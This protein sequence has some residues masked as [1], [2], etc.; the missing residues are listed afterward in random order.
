MKK[1]P[2]FFH[3]HKNAGTYIYHSSWRTFF[4]NPLASSRP[5]NLEILKENKVSYRMICDLKDETQDEKYIRLNRSGVD[6]RVD[7]DD[8]DFNDL[9]IYFIEICG[10]SF[11]SYKEEI[12]KNLPTDLE[13]YEF[14][15]LREPYSRIQSLYSYIHT[16]KP[17]NEGICDKSFVEY[18]NSSELECGW[19]IRVLSDIPN[20][21]PICQE[22]YD[23]TCRILDGM[24]VS[25][26]D[27]VDQELNKIFH[28]CYRI[29]A[30][31]SPP[32]FSNK[33]QEKINI[34]FNQLDDN[35]K[36]TFLNNTKWDIK[37]YNRYFTTD[38]D[39]YK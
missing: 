29:K 1:L 5:W 34:S 2:V 19:L 27:N 16:M 33:T 17:I 3:I 12:Y 11:N 14:I 8:L 25:N 32:D 7:I 31:K 13:L 38:I 21:I 22:H 39:K 36:T 35:T 15:F 20:N 28:H 6:R 10:F 37:L 24:H 4:I 26:T 18:L 9:H 30:E 23:E